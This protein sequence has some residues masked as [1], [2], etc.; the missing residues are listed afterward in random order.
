MRSRIPGAVAVAALVAVAAA[1]AAS[2]VHLAL[3]RGLPQPVAGRGWTARLTVRP[4]SFAGTVR[5]TAAGTT[6]LSVRATGGRGA[7]RARL[8][9]P[10]AGHW[11]LTGRA[12]GTTSRLGAVVVRVRPRTPLTFIWP[13]SIDTEPGGSLL[14]VENGLE[15]VLRV[16]TA[17]GRVTTLAS[18]IS[19]AYA[20]ARAPSGSVYVSGAHDLFRIDGT[21]PPVRVAEADSDLGPIAVSPAGDVYFAT[22]TQIFVVR[23]GSS[24]PAPVSTAQLAAPHGLAVT[25]DGTL[26]VSDTGHGRVL[27]IDPATGGA[28]TFAA[29]DEPRGVDVAADGSVYVVDARAKRVL[30]LSASGERLG[31]AGPAFTDPYDVAV[32]PDGA[33][34]VVDTAVAGRVLRVAAD[35]TATPLSRG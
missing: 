21:A 16:D 10:T 24:P 25:R 3:A 30:H 12:G 33:Q 13:T 8:V 28:T 26:L 17:T 23:G 4:A 5:V 29:I 34:Y 2:R 27:L 6:R 9:F 1:P 19:K 11:T 14:V 7:Y 35:G 15:R 32:A 18:G 31:F 22:A 20:V